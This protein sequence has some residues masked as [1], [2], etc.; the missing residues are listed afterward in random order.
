MTS[1]VWEYLEDSGTWTAFDSLVQ[2]ALATGF[3]EYRAGRSGSVATVTVP[4]RPQA[5]TIDYARGTQRN[6][7]TLRERA[8]RYREVRSRLPSLHAGR[9]GGGGG[10]YVA[11]VVA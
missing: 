9:V 7:V 5:Y 1:G 2:G 10:T 11:V 6:T 8:V 3:A 4:G